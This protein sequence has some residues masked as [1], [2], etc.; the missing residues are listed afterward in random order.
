VPSPLESCAAMG[1][2]AQDR[3][4]L[5]S[6]QR[7]HGDNCTIVKKPHQPSAALA[8]AGRPHP[9]SASLACVTLYQRLD[10]GCAPSPPRD[11][12]L[13]GLTDKSGPFLA[14]GKDGGDLLERSRRELRPNSLRPRLAGDVAG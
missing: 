9:V 1:T 12:P 8:Q 14:V 2:P 5:P 7:R 13:D 3:W 6:P 10:R 4:R 11:L